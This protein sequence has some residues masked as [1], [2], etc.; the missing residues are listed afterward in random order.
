M[1]SF[2]IGKIINKENNKICVLTASGVG[3]EINLPTFLFLELKNNQEVQIPVYLAVRENSQDL[4]G[5]KDLAQKDL[6]L[7]FLDVNGIGPKSALHLLSLGTVAEISG[8]IARGD[9]EYLTKVSGV[10][11]KT[12]ER[13]VVELKN[14]VSAL[15]GSASGGQS[16]ELAGTALGEVVDALVSLGYSKEEARETV[17]SLDSKDKTSEELLKLAFKVLSK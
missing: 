15:G 16:S 9:V 1:I 17:K 8:A 10:G 2:L 12:A 13:I 3:Y 5:F 6:F 7:K 4:Y 14:K 11:K